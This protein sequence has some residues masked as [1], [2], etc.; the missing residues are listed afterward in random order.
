MTNQAGKDMTQGSPIKLILAFFVPLMLGMLFQQFYSMMDTI[1]VGKFLGVQALAAVGSTGSIN[2]MVIGFCM[3]VCSG[4]AIPVAQRFGAKDYHYLRKYVANGVFLAVVFAIVM[5]VGVCLL[6][7]NILHWMN[8]PPDILQGAYNYIF[9]IFLGIPVIYMYNLL[10]GIIRSLG[11]SKS[12]LLFLIISSLLNIVLDLAL[13][14]WFDMGVGGAAWA[15]VISQGISGILCL[16]YMKKRYE[17]LKISKEEWK[18]DVSCMK[19]LCNMGIPMGLQYSITA[20]GS[21][22]LQTAVNTLGSTAVASVTAANKVGMFFCCPFDAMGSTMSTYA[23]QNL[24]AGELK[25]VTKGMLSCCLLGL[26]YAVFA[27]LV[28]FFFGTKLALLFL[29]AGEVAILDNVRL[30]LVIGS[31]FYF[32]LALV[33]IIRFTIQGLGYSKLAIV[34]GVCEMVARAVVGAFLVPAAG[35]LGACF[36]SPAAW[37]FADLFLIPAY[38]SV[39]K[40]LQRKN[41]A[42]GD[43]SVRS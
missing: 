5:T 20:I 33:N 17:I 31:A 32:A 38:I 2:F 10:S 29:D 16:V 39:M 3:G 8:T 15:T 25:R 41:S 43:A 30:Y 24:G 7:N 13:I 19:K 42:Q 23:G 18:P 40:A 1:I 37:I 28:L 12:P 27:F 35:Y 14:L 9:V 6:C 21:V 26:G 34:A 36:A 22:I 11:D 4:F